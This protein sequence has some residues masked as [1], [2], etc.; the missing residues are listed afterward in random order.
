MPS[1]TPLS[2]SQIAD[3]FGALDDFIGTGNGVNAIFQTTYFPVIDTRNIT[4]ELTGVGDGATTVYQLFFF[5]INA[6]TLELHK[7][8]ING[9]LLVDPTHYTVNLA[10]GVVT[11]TLTGVT[12]LGTE[13]LHSKYVT[14]STLELHSGTITGPL[15]TATTHYKLAPQTGK[16]TLTAAGITFLGT[17]QLHAKYQIRTG[18]V[19]VLTEANGSLRAS[20]VV[21]GIQRGIYFSKDASLKY[22][23]ETI[24]TQTLVDLLGT[25]G[26]EPERR[27]LQNPTAIIIATSGNYVT[28]A[29][30]VDETK[31]VDSVTLPYRP[32]VRP[33]YPFGAAPNSPDAASPF[34]ADGLFGGSGTDPSNEQNEIL[35]EIGAQ[36][37]VIAAG[38]NVSGFPG[39]IPPRSGWYL[40]YDQALLFMIPAILAENAALAVQVTAITAFLVANPFPT[41]ESPTPLISA[42]NIGD[43]TAASA[44]AT[45]QIAT[46][47]AYLALI[48][49]PS[50]GPYPGLSNANLAARA[51]TQATR[52]TFITARI[53][54]ITTHLTLLY[55]TRFFWVASRTRLSDGTKR[56]YITIGTA[57]TSTNTQIADNTTRINE[58]LVT[59]GAQ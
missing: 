15:L 36:A 51:A 33:L 1:L 28:A 52:Q 43:A 26:I 56:K 4:D 16:I 45:A 58:T 32:G 54:Q 5:P 35:T 17:S 14:P 6:G 18:L 21:Q 59:L 12:F 11:L 8:A 10:T 47:N 30:K 7:T 37:A 27:A 44:A 46:N 39:P 50:A 38:A 34:K 40:R 2:P 22:I 24:E 57:I 3:L 31:I 53:A 48:P 13:Q 42:G 19:N 23:H 29:E 49:Y 25:G 9:P 20:V 55:S 41:T